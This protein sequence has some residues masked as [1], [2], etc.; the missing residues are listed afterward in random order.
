MPIGT[1]DGTQYES[2]F[3]AAMDIPTDLT[4]PEEKKVTSSE[5]KQVDKSTQTIPRITVT[6]RREPEDLSIVEKGFAGALRGLEAI[7]LGSTSM[8]LFNSV[9]AGR[10]DPITENDLTPEDLDKFRDIVVNHAKANGK[11][12]GRIDYPDYDKYSSPHGITNLK[13]P[14]SQNILGGFG[15]SID[16]NG[17]ILITDKYDFN[18]V[19]QQSTGVDKVLED[20]LS[21]SN[22]IVQAAVGALMPRNLGNKIGRA[23]VPPGKGAAVAIKIPKSDTMTF[24]P[25]FGEG[26]PGLVDLAKGSDELLGRGVERKQTFPEKVVRSLVDAFSLPR[27]VLQEGED[28]QDPANI[29]R[30]FELAS[31]LVFGPM[32]VAKKVADGTL[33]S[34]AGVQAAIRNPE[35]IAELD[36]AMAMSRMNASQ[37]AIYNSTGFWKDK[38]GHWKFE[39]SDKGAQFTVNKDKMELGT[40]YYLDQ[41]LYHPEL[42]KAY[43]ELG[44]IR[45]QKE[46]H[47][48][49]DTLGYASKDE[50]GPFIVLTE[51]S[52][53]NP[54][55]TLH[56]VQHVIQGIEGFARGGATA[57]KFKLRFEEDIKQLQR[58]AMSILDRNTGT[59]LNSAD[60]ERL[61]LIQKIFQKDIARKREAKIQ[62]THNYSRLA[63]EIE[64]RNVQTRFENHPLP[65]SKTW[66]EVGDNFK[67]YG[68][69][70]DQ[71]RNSKSGWEMDN[72]SLFDYK[73]RKRGT[74]QYIEFD[75]LPIHLQKDFFKFTGEVRP[76]ELPP[77]ITEDV[78]QKG[79]EIGFT[80]KLATPYG[81][82][83]PMKPPPYI[84]K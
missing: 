71:V 75:E 18:P 74:S 33:G 54:S 79:A 63:G 3:H 16:D 72:S 47:L 50:H 46:K 69:A 27:R 66:D 13:D 77:Y 12:T 68:Y 23:L 83:D 55:I 10:T 4:P 21:E 42:Y 17:E 70:I 5:E 31:T 9:T 60:A 38:D 78:F 1:S 19:S 49:G 80:P 36:N 82:G 37:D 65:P 73:F 15:Y 7:G 59:H 30:A 40:A 34:F 67:E 57:E 35:R 64:S 28:A 32:P 20:N 52:L 29:G 53:K 81:Y 43:P 11:S 39:I 14:V 76:R 51:D 48:G 58:E 41:I 6:P 62:A 2:P 56:E 61:Q 44:K 22:P 26:D 25:A 24:K 8:K 45:I 84:P